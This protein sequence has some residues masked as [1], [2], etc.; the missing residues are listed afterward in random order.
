M[1]APELFRL[2]LLFSSLSTKYYILQSDFQISDL[3]L[4]LEYET[5]ELNFTGL[6]EGF[7]PVVQALIV[8]LTHRATS[9]VVGAVR[10]MVATMA[11]SLLCSEDEATATYPTETSQIFYDFIDFK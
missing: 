7:E 3:Q 10:H 8:S 9:L 5:V 1:F 4:S 11:T 6:D 2:F